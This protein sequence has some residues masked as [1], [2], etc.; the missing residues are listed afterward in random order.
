MTF[1]LRHISLLIGILTTIL[2]FL[3]FGRDTKT[4]DILL[5][6]GLATAGIS[7]L[8]V[9]FRKDTFKSK[10]LW[11]LVVIAA[12]GMQWITEPLFIKLSYRYFIKLHENNL[13]SA[14]ALIRTKK[15]DLFLLVSELRT[16]DGFKQQEVNQIRDEF[17]NT[18]I[19]LIVKDSL[20]IFY[21][22]WGMLDISHGI[23]YF[24]PGNKP[25]E[26]YKQIFGNWYY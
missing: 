2:S 6:V 1:S 25:H 10:L 12:V 9:L 16:E 4:Y 17:K 26:R 22:T 14:T 13:N 18:G 5:L 19:H 24:Y 3:W 7:Y 8:I 11:T 15:N 20:K 23:Y 21:R